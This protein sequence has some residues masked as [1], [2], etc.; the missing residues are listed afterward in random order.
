[1]TIFNCKA[2]VI[3]IHKTEYHYSNFF[4]LSSKKHT[5]IYNN[6]LAGMYVCKHAYNMS[7]SCA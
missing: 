4:Y 5:S 1:M 2:M 7:I 6:V 3:I